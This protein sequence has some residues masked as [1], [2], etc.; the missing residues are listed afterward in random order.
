MPIR[1]IPR[2]IEEQ[3]GGKRIGLSRLNSPCDTQKKVNFPVLG[4]IVCVSWMELGSSGSS[5][6][7]TAVSAGHFQAGGFFG[8]VDTVVIVY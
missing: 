1:E 6:Y 3:I 7:L 2:L 5:V 4:L 8:F